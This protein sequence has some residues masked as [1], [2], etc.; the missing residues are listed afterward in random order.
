MIKPI[1]QYQNGIDKLVEDL[2]EAVDNIQN[3]SFE[4]LPV[5]Q[6]GEYQVNL[7]NFNIKASNLQSNI[8]FLFSL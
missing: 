1:I 7:T 5:S 4:N 2:S 6:I 8:I 3:G